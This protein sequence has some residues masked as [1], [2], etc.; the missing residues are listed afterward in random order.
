MDGDGVGEGDL[1]QFAVIVNGFASFEI[2]AHFF[3][4][5]VDRGD[6][7][8]VAVEDFLV[9]VVFGL[10]D[11]V[12]NAELPAEFLDGR[13]EFAFGV[14]FALEEDVEFAD[15]EGATIH[16]GENL[17]VLKGIEMKFAWDAGLHHFLEGGEDCFGGIALDEVEVSGVG[18]VCGVRK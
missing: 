2:D 12:A 8:D 13:V 16:G 11:F 4:A 6:V 5:G 3:F 9:V 17:D 18:G 10:D 1:I 7:T 14:E 15:T